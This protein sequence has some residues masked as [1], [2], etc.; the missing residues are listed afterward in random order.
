MP[1]IPFVSGR[2]V[3]AVEVNDAID[4][5]IRSRYQT[6]DQT[7]TNSTAFLSSPDLVCSVAANAWY[8]FDSFIIVDT[9]ATADFKF[10]LALPAGSGAVLS[11]WGSGVLAA[12]ISDVIFH[13][14]LNT[15][16][17]PAGGVAAGTLM[18]MR[19]AGILAIGATAGS[20][21]FQFAQNTA[22]A[23]GTILKLGS[24]M[25]LSRVA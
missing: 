22:N 18:S 2:R 9:N 21:T 6:A 3:R 10:N 13:D 15:T 25:K 4:D 14:V 19:P 7:R 16:T 24:W 1:R 8:T 5:A 20:C 11:L 23:V 12:S 17:I